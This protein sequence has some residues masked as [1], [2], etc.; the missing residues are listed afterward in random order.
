MTG[1]EV[2]LLLGVPDDMTGTVASG[3]PF[4]LRGNTGLA[5]ALADRMREQQWPVRIQLLGPGAGPRPGAARLLLNAIC[6]PVIHR[7]SLATLAGLEMRSGLPVLNPWWVIAHTGR[8]AIAR[9]LAHQ[10]GVHVPRCTVF[11]RERGNLPE[12][13]ERTG[14]RYPV[15][16]RPLG[17]HGSDGLQRIDDASQAAAVPGLPTAHVTD[18]V[19]F[20]SPDGLYR[21]YRL[22]YAG[23]QLIRRHLFIDDQWNITVKARRFMRPRPDLVEEEERWLLRPIEIENG[24][25]DSRILHQFRALQLDFGSIDYGLL[26]D[27]SVLVFEINACIQIHGAVTPEEEKLW[28]HVHATDDRIIGSVLDLVRKRAAPPR[29]PVA[30]P[31]RATRPGP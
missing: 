15:L 13:V 19:D 8:A 16:V 29:P 9:R 3:Q 14:H 30:P 12:H 28:P 6:E 7:R 24:T 23:D 11:Q 20:R 25:V 17:Q 2:L 18:W 10:V 31:H 27:G 26:P 4:N 21:K 22:F 5:A 1:P